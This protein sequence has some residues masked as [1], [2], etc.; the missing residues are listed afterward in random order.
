MK[1]VYRNL[2]LPLFSDPSDQTS[3]QDSKSLV[4]QTVGTQE[5]IVMSA[6]ISHTHNLSIYGRAWVSNIFQKGLEFVTALFK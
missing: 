4:D 3:K 5:I 2:L 1:L 6:V